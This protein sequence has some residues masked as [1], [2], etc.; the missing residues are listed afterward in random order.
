M[1]SV[2]DVVVDKIE[3]TDITCVRKVVLLKGHGDD[4]KT[5]ILKD[6][7]RQLH[8]MYPNAWALNRRGNCKTSFGS[9]VERVERV[10]FDFG[11]SQMVRSAA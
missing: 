8:E 2:E 4:G 11:M 5:T 3:A 10:D 6:V 7:V 1:K 9:R